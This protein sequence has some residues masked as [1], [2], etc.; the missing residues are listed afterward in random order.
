MDDVTPAPEKTVPLGCQLAPAE[1][2]L[3]K[4]V[5]CPP[6]KKAK[7]ITW[8]EFWINHSSK[9]PSFLTRLLIICPHSVNSKLK[10]VTPPSSLISSCTFKVDD[11][12]RRS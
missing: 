10:E 4:S 5:G 7:S 9:T 3:F 8:E 1:T 12:K 2:K 6:I 11:K